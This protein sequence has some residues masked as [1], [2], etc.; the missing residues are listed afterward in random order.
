MSDTITVY[1]WVNPSEFTPE[2]G[3]VQDL[4][5]SGRLKELILRKLD[6]YSEVTAARWANGM[7]VEVAG[8]EQT[9]EVL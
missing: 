8:I 2:N 6:S 5:E 7:Y 1:E 9:P 3:W 4:I